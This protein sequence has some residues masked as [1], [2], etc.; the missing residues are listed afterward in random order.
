MWIVLAAASLSTA[1]EDANANRKES[2]EQLTAAGRELKRHFASTGLT[3]ATSGT[4]LPR[5]SSPLTTAAAVKVASNKVV[6]KRERESTASTIGKVSSAS[7]IGI[8]ESVTKKLK[9]APEPSTA[10]NSNAKSL[11]D[12]SV[13]SFI[14]STGG[15]LT[16]NDLVKV[17]Y[18]TV[19]SECRVDWVMVG[20]LFWFLGF[21]Y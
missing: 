8:S 18:M 9:I 5:T 17:C 13:R 1:S 16:L 7:S 4:V 11:T 10:G 14:Q 15:K 12:E 3:N 19:F 2:L 20:H 21:F 6:V